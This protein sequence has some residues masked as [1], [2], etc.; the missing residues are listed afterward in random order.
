ML[1]ALH[2]LIEK[3]KLMRLGSGASAKTAISPLMQQPM[4]AGEGFGPVAR[5]LLDKRHVAWEPT[6]AER[7]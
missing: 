6:T 4:L 3:G 5:Q 7:A 1:R 2:T